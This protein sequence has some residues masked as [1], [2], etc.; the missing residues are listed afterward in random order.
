MKKC[1]PKRVCERNPATSKRFYS[2]VFEL[3]FRTEVMVLEADET[4]E[5]AI[6]VLQMADELAVECDLNA[7]A[8]RLDLIG[9]PLPNRKRGQDVGRGEFIYGPGSMQRGVNDLWVYVR[10]FPGVIDLKLYALIDVTLR[11]V[12]RHGAAARL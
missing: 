4:F 6:A 9:V 7:I 3:H 1:V 10:V 2:D 11:I 5:Q 8:V 12:R